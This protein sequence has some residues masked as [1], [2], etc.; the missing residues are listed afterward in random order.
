MTI[1]TPLFVDGDGNV[2]EMTSAQ[3]TVIKDQAAAL[4]L[5][6]P[7]VTLSWSATNGTTGF[8][9]NMADTR[10][11]SGEAS[12]VTGFTFPSETDTQEPQLKTINWRR[13]EQSQSGDTIPTDTNN[14]RYPLY[15]VDDGGGDF[16]LQSMTE[17]DFYDT[18]ISDAIDTVSGT[19][20]SKYKIHTATTLTDYTSLGQV[21]S[22]T[23]ANPANMTAGEIGTA[24]T[25]QEDSTTN[26]NYYLME[27][28]SNFNTQTGY[29][30]PALI[31]SSGDVDQYTEAEFNA[32]L[33]ANMQYTAAS[34]AAGALTYS[35]ST[36]GTAL[37]TNIVNKAM[38]SAGTGDYQTRQVNTNDYRAQEFP[39]GTVGTINT[40]KLVVTKA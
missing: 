29:T 32:I 11:I 1:R 26:A 27:R 15:Y 40:W 7:S 37:G 22:D 33:L 38:T 35:V 20:L 19:T 8:L 9:A 18:F 25:T 34:R 12:V 39:N 28:T 4:Y 16:T 24:G 10:Y 3:I 31:T 30:I 23:Q 6:S 14:V 13:I 5:A 21:F 36:T 2:Q 17:Q